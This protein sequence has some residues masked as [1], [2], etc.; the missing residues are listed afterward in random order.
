[1][2]KVVMRLDKARNVWTHDPSGFAMVNWDED[3]SAVVNRD[4]VS[5][6]KTLE[7]ARKAYAAHQ[8]VD[9]SEVEI[10]FDGSV[11]AREVEEPIAV[12]M[13]NFLKA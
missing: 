7:T 1:M 4:P 10:V 5:R 9:E 8:R 2:R 11:P 13:T 6:E 3:P 12:K